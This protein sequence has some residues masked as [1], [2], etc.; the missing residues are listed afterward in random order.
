MP[1]LVLLDLKLPKVHG[2]EVLCR[3][4]AD[5]RTRHLAVVILTSSKEEQDLIEGYKLQPIPTCASRWTLI[6]LLNCTAAW[7]VPADFERGAFAL[8]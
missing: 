7:P 3:L 6:N 5:E 2:L 8:E 1:Q 4:R